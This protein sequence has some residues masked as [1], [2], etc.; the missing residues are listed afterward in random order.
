MLRPA[1]ARAGTSVA[2]PPPILPT[3]ALLPFPSTPTALPRRLP[4]TAVYAAPAQPVYVQETAAR[5]GLTTGQGVALGAAG[6][7]LGGMLL[8]DLA[9]PH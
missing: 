4:C 3:A 6:G 9:S 8:A 7:F 1:A 2:S 5:P